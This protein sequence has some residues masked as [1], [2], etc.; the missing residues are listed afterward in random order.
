M[1]EAAAGSAGRSRP[2][3]AARASDRGYFVDRSG[4]IPSR[5]CW[6]GRGVSGGR[7]NRGTIP[8]EL[9]PILDRLGL[10]RERLAEED[11]SATLAAGLGRCWCRRTR[12]RW[13]PP[14][15]GWWLSLV[16]GSTGRDDCFSVIASSA[17]SDEDV[18]KAI[19]NAKTSRRPAPPAA[20]PEPMQP[21]RKRFSSDR[22]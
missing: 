17:Q 21:Y 11:E 16:P 6:T 8:G 2:T 13:R 5:R 10:N 3:L 15:A 22:D 9:S 7:G 18:R 1:A 19:G 12:L 20:K 4:E 14:S